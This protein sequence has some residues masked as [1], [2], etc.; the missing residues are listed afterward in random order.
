MKSNYKLCQS[1]GKLI[2]IKSKHDGSSKYCES[3]AKRIKNEQN[4]EYYHNNKEI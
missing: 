3:C 4:K 1:C 2:K